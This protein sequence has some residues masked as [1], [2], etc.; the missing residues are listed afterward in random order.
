MKKGFMLLFCLCS[1]ALPAIGQAPLEAGAANGIPA[2]FPVPFDLGL[3]FTVPGWAGA[4]LLGTG[5]LLFLLGGIWLLVLAF[6]RGVGWGLAC[7]LLPPAQIIF[8]IMHWR[9]AWQAAG[10][11]FLGG[12]LTVTGM[13]FGFATLAQHM[14]AV[15]PEMAAVVEQQQ[16]ALAAAHAAA[17]PERPPA[18]PGKDGAGVLRIGDTLASVEQRFG[19]PGGRIK[20]GLHL[21]LMYPGFSVISED[22]ATVADVQQNARSDGMPAA[23][24]ARKPRAARKL[25]KP[26]STETI[27]AIH[28][29]G[30]RLEL[31]SVL[32]PG[33]VTV[34]D[35]HAKWCGPCKA[36][37]PILEGIAKNDN[38]VFLR[39]VDIVRWGTPVTEQYGIRSIPNV[40][41]YDG[42]GRLIGR[43]TSSIG[44][45]RQ[46]IQQAK[47]S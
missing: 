33:S 47:S 22:G 44:E 14:Q 21:I 8:V 32:V 30:K 16:A 46:Y 42:L 10:V 23:A 13:V 2:E 29:G 37:G 34:I 25:P 41:V 20:S 1:L 26:Y 18:A 6:G 39:Q 36:M 3:P 38:K 4:A 7:L 35:F 11:A 40:R 43:P 19:A 31:E 17:N 27:R 15:L 12:L 9:D 28:N 24:P 5:F 45:I